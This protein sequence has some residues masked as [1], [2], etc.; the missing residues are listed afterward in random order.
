M[1]SE[2][3]EQVV[4]VRRPLW[5]RIAKWVAIVLAALVALLLI[6]V[7]GVNTGP[8]RRTLANFLGGYRTASGLNIHVDRIEG[9]IY[10]QMRLVGLQVRDRH[11]TF[12][13]SPEV[14]VDWRPF[15]F[16][17]NH[18]DIRSARAAQI[19]MLR[20][21][22]LI[23]VATDPNAPL[24]PDIDIDIGRLTVD[25]FL[26]EAPVAGARHLISIDGMTHIAD[27]RAQLI[28]QADA[29]TAPGISG[30][31]RLALRLDA[32]P[33]QDRLE[34]AAR[35]QA[36]AGGVMAAMVGFTAPLQAQ[37]GGRGSWS[38]WNGRAIAT[39]GGQSF[40]DLG[41]HAASG[42]FQVRGNLHPAL[43]PGVAPAT[44]AA[45]ENRDRAPTSANPIAALTAPALQVAIDTTLDQRVAN[46]RFAVRSDALAVNGQGLIDLARS[47]FGNFQVDARLVTP[48]AI[49]PN[50]NGRDVAAHLA[51]D[52]AFRT[53][54]VAYQINAA[55]LGF[56]TTVVQGLA[57]SGR[58]VVNADNIQVPIHA[59]ARAIG[60]LNAAVGGL[61]T[62]VGIDGS[63]AITGDT[64]LSDNLRIRSDK[65]NATAIIV[66]DLSSGTYRGA[67][68]GRI[69]DYLVQGVGIVSL[70]TNARLVTLPGGGFGIT[71][72]IAARTQRIFNAGAQSFLGGNAV[73]AADVGYAPDGIVTFRNLRLSAPLFAVTSGEGRYNPN[74]QL[75]VN[76]QAYSRTY[77]PLT[78]QVTGTTTDPV[79]LLRAARPGVGVGLV[80][81]EARVR[82]NNGSYAVVATGG[83]N[84]GPFS[85]NVVVTPGTALTVQ[86][87]LVRFAGIDFTG[88]VQQMTA[89][90][91]AGRL[92]F[93][94]S[95]ING[96]AL[97]GSVG[98]VQSADIAARA[99]AAHI[100]GFTDFTIGRA[101]VNA[102][103]V[104]YPSAPRVLADAQV[105]DLR[106]GTTVLSTARVRVDY[107]NGSG[108]AQAVASGSSGVPFRVA[109]NARLS[110]RL[111]LAALQ[112]QAN[113]IAFRTAAPARIEVGQGY[114]LLPTR[115]DFSNGSARIAGMYARGMSFQARLDRLDLSMLNAFAPG[116]GLGGSATGSVD[117]VQAASGALPQADARLTISNFTRSGLASVSQPVDI[118]FLGRMQPAGA[119][120]RAL[121]QRGGTVV[122]RMVAT[123]APGGGSGL[124]RLMN[125]SLAGGI[126]YS[127]PASVLFS[128]GGF[129][130]QQ[131]TGGIVLAADFSGQ[132]AAPQVNGLVRADNLTY[133]NTTLGTRIFNMQ[134]AGQF[135]R[136]RFVLQR[137][138]GSAGDGTLQAQGSVGLAA[139]SGFPVDVTAQLANAR[140]ASSDALA[141]TATGT[142]HI[143]HGTDGGLIEGN[144]QIPN[145]RYEIIRQGA[146]EVPELT[147]VRRRGATV[148]TAAERAAAAA[149]AGTFRLNL[150][151]T[152][153]N[154]LYV[155]GMGLESEWMADMRVTGSSAAPVVAGE[156]R[157]IRGTYTFSG[158]RFTVDRG[159]VRFNGGPLSDPDID[160]SA[161][162]TVQDVSAVINVTG[163]G[164]HPQIAFTSTPALP[165]D[166]VLSR[167]LFGSSV[168]NL[169]AT[170]AIQLAAALNGL[171]SS[172]GGGLN[173]LGALRSATGIDRLRLLG[174]DQASGR[175]TSLAAG[176][177]ITRNIYVEIITD[178]RGFTA[179]QLEI[180]LS[181]ALS[182]LSSAGSAGGNNLSFRYRRDF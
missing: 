160:I 105:Q 98:G 38:Q 81:L 129:A 58:A 150:H 62:N 139:A 63:L 163:T 32:V 157:L 145:A 87:N 138:T 13:T 109:L 181:R 133:D 149:P 35:V 24:L 19:R 140:L 30:G 18:V 118:Q 116:L 67:I 54:T 76:A 144:L 6:L 66:A 53:P 170:E 77:G 28:V 99:Y 10:G 41:L 132:L 182:L 34:L 110:P 42:T 91:F 180:S 106:Y 9:S 124:A 70:N 92:N 164:Q 90:P 166:E 119:E 95:G 165:Q 43:Y 12:L 101:I 154:Q 130:N 20:N 86:V 7:V 59:T 113:G 175:G 127:G 31:D 146:A 3:P 178:A 172:G 128:F 89:G 153:Q 120:A 111:W 73:I 49:T 16:L 85:A 147:G 102:R 29:L 103:V 169:S 57:A 143:T 36:P 37:I 17:S 26:M 83:T 142:I 75:L 93:A 52:G 45:R 108:T 158:K 84:Y 8:G 141:A 61:V 162:T 151:L 69:N 14:D 65:V 121:I 161:S 156:I 123:V 51:L 131:L 5:Q 44:A 33:D 21:P 117:Y 15:A 40:A 94:G 134:L 174:A 137:L 71:A 96:T 22:D 74:G 50:L 25:R 78:A 56:G 152:A 122:G 100:P 126:R 136:D 55:T 177:Y 27:R 107:Q 88:R 39:L 176:K 168:T 179:T 82:G 11:G 148:P 72:H 68:N 115:I 171:R 125:G 173:P 135:T 47:T 79:V 64:I 60:G 104:L 114:R 48:G 97:L 23:P 2:A 46:T 159:V 112:G 80:N 1:A 4:I 155:S 167:L